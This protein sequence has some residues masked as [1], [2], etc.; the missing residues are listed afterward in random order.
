MA[1]ETFFELKGADEFK[2]AIRRNPQKILDLVGRFIT[3][4]LAE[5]KKIIIRSPWRIGMSGGGAPVMT[6]NLRDTHIT[7]VSP[8][9]GRIYPSAP[10][11]QAVHKKRP[12]LDYAKDT[13]S[14]NVEKLEAELLQDIVAD[15]AK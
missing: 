11:S 6:G 8:F 13:A 3:R 1:K 5:Y 15:L 9:A 4:G 2:E 12:W 7:E 10:Y 14:P